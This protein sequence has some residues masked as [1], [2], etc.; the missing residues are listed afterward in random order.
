ME[1]DEWWQA[2]PSG[3]ARASGDERDLRFHH[4]GAGVWRAEPRDERDWYANAR[5]D[6]PTY[7]QVIEEPPAQPPVPRAGRAGRLAGGAAAGAGRPA[8]RGALRVPEV[9]LAFW[10]V[11]ALST[12][13]GES[14]SDALVNSSLGAQVAVV[15]GFVAFLAGLALQF[16]QGRCYRTASTGLHAV[17]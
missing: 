1:R 6:V 2:D 13:M 7:T 14:T 16:K 11:K 15:A 5:G 10:S 8:G 17:R 12:A 4:R 3:R 9:A